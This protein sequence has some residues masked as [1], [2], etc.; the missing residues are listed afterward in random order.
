MITRYMYSADCI[1]L[2]FALDLPNSLENVVKKAST[3]HAALGLR[4]TALP[5]VTLSPR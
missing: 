4:L 1:M 2:C 3:I 5:V